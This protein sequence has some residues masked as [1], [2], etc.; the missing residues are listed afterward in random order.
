MGDFFIGKNLTIELDPEQ[1]PSK[2]DKRSSITGFPAKL[3]Y[4]SKLSPNTEKSTEM[5]TEAS[6]SIS[7]A[8]SR[9]ASTSG[10]NS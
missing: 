3:T 7:S 2:E 9:Q 5:D 8:T 1:S 4:R 6:L 10:A